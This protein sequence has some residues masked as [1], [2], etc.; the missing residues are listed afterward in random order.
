MTSILELLLPL[1]DCP[2]D[3]WADGISCIR[4]VDILWQ[5]D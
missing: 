4:R 2:D 1:A 3:L 5:T